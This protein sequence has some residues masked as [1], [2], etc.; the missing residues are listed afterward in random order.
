[1]ERSEFVCAVFHHLDGDW[2]FLGPSGASEA[3]A[4]VVGLAQVL[5]LDATLAELGDLERGCGARRHR[6]GEPWTRFR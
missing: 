3:D 4:R 1:M 6:L 5:A 2:Q